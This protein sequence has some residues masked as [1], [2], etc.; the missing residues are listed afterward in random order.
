M[1]KEDLHLIVFSG[2]FSWESGGLAGVHTDGDI[3]LPLGVQGW[4]GQGGGLGLM[5]RGRLVQNL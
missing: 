4:L 1:E 2:D 5:R 3:I